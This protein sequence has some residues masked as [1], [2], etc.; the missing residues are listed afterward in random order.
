[1]KLIGPWD[2]MKRFHAQVAGA[3]REELQ[4]AG[5]EVATMALESVKATARATQ[6]MLHPF[7]MMQKGSGTPLMGGQLEEGLLA[8]TQLMPIGGPFV[9]VWVGVRGELAMIAAVQQE[10]ASIPATENMRNY[11]ASQ[12]L[13]LRKDTRYVVIPPRPFIEPGLEAVRGRATYLFTRAFVRGF[14]RRWFG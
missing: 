6:P 9:D 10:G 3:V 13:H 7:T 4:S 14:K 5:N 11:L 1:M 12:G 8:E 2:A